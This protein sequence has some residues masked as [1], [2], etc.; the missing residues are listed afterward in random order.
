MYV[1][2]PFNY[3]G[4]K[5]KILDQLLPLFDYNKQNFVDLFAGGGS[6]Y[7]NILNKYN[8]IAVNDIIGELIEIQKKLV[9]DNNIINDVKKL[10]VDKEDKEGYLELRKNYNENKSPEKL[11]ALM[12]CCTNN[13]I[14]FNEL[15][16]N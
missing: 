10:V 7:T 4:S 6:V 3:T 5:Y 11:W 8:K 13:M 1:K 16:T 2:T 14:R 12:L 9:T 15:H